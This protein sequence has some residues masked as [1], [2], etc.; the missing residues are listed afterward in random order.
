MS[1]AIWHVAPLAI[2]MAGG[3]LG[4][5]MALAAPQS[6]RLGLEA[7]MER[8]MNAVNA[9]DVNGLTA[10]MTEDVELLDVNGATVAGRDAAIRALN[11]LAT[12]GR[13]V[14]MN[15]EIKV[16][17]TVAWRVVGFT[18]TQKNGDVH[19]RGQALE[20]WNRVNGEWKLHR[21]SAGIVAPAEVLTRP[22]KGDPVLDRP[23]H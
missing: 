20:I 7:A 16:A 14:A 5:A 21:Q 10:T 13:L 22:P 17:N 23:A 1:K 19:A 3:L 9:Q 6:E 4:C 8:W 15:R 11:E 12:R 2:L 18:Q